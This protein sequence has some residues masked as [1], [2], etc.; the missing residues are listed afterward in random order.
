MAPVNVVESSDN[1]HTHIHFIRFVPSF[2]SNT[3]RNSGIAI[4]SSEFQIFDLSY[5]FH[6]IIIWKSWH[7]LNNKRSPPQL[8]DTDGLHNVKRQSQISPVALQAEALFQY[9]YLFPSSCLYIYDI[10]HNRKF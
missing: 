4:R 8:P 9:S 6:Q 3:P 2:H 1:F 10:Y 7:M 5:L